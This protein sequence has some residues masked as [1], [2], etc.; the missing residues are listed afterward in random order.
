MER[1]FI[2]KHFIPGTKNF[3][4][5]ELLPL[6][7]YKNALMLD[8]SEKENATDIEKL[9]R[10]NDWKNSWKDCIYDYH[11]YHSTAHEAMGIYSGSAKI[12]I[13]GPQGIMLE[14]SKGDVLII[15]AGVAHKSV[16][17][18]EDFQC[19]GAYPTG[20]EYDIKYGEDGERPEAD[21]NIAN[22]LL[23]THDPVFG[24][25]GPLDKWWFIHDK[26][27]LINH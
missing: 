26:Y 27:K 24:K 23:P 15:P 16:H 4:N 22:V 18:T 9:F 19:V 2:I 6:L 1:I 20:Q 25:Q 12:Q 13:G 11:H 3:P 5:N 7:F 21:I 17:G 10:K 8:K 14:I